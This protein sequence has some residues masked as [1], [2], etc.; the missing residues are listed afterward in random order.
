MLWRP[1]WLVT[2]PSKGINTSLLFSSSKS[3]GIFWPF[4]AFTSPSEGLGRQSA[5]SLGLQKGGRKWQPP[6]TAAALWREATWSLGPG[7]VRT[8]IATAAT[9]LVQ[10]EP[11]LDCHL[12]ISWLPYNTGPGRLSHTETQQAHYFYF[13]VYSSLSFNCLR[14]KTGY[15]LPSPLHILF[16]LFGLRLI[17]GH[18]GGFPYCIFISLSLS[19]IL[20]W[21]TCMLIFSMPHVDG[22][23]S[24]WKVMHVTRAV[25]WASQKPLPWCLLLLL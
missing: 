13:H 6:G 2:R 15:H 7:T 24:T 5:A 18:P 22:G 21:L 23:H 10:K 9:M 19:V 12:N 11:W 14:S 16:L 8:R 20:H 4:K 25:H 17:Q 1:S 3:E